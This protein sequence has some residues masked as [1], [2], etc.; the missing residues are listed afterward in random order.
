MLLELNLVESSSAV[1]E[2]LLKSSAGAI[3]ATG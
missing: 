1:V 2:R 3:Q